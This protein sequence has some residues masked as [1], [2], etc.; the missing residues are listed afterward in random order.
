[1]TKDII[2]AFQ[3]RST[4]QKLQHLTLLADL[5]PGN[6]QALLDHLSDNHHDSKLLDRMISVLER[7][8]DVADAINNRK[9][10]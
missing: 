7:L 3:L 1:M 9:G 4:P 8:S 10:E 5:A 6:L 2:R